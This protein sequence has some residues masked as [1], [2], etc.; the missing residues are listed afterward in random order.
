LVE[1]NERNYENKKRGQKRQRDSS[2]D[3]VKRTFKA[4]TARNG[5][6]GGALQGQELNRRSST[7]RARQNNRVER[8]AI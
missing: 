2:A 8:F 1:P 4:E 5:R 6:H 7:G 3:D